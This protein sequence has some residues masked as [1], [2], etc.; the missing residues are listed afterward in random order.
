MPATYVAPPNPPATTAVIEIL[1]RWHA[2]THGHFEGSSDG[3]EPSTPSFLTGLPSAVDGVAAWLGYIN[4]ILAVFNLLPASPLDARTRSR[5]ATQK[6]PRPSS[7]APG[8]MSC[9]SRTSTSRFSTG[10]T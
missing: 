8:S 5:S 7:S 2:L 6:P 3:L 1:R 10:T 9:D 4:L